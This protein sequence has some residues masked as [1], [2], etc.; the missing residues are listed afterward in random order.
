[1]TN[2]YSSDA[3]MPREGI[4]E[5]E[6]PRK[7]RGRPPKQPETAPSLTT[8]KLL[9]NINPGPEAGVPK[10]EYDVLGRIVKGKVIDLPAELARKLIKAK[11]AS[12]DAAFD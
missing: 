8:V 3:E 4:S 5:A 9:R 2:T 6:A 12:A 11:I 7:S 1:M 10:S